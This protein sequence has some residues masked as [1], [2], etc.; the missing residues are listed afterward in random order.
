MR[1]GFRVFNWGVLALFLF[2]G[3]SMLIFGDKAFNERNSAIGALFVAVAL[4]SVCWVPVVA[5][6]AVISRYLE[7]R[8]IFRENMSV[9]EVIKAPAVYVI[10]VVI[11]LFVLLVA[12]NMT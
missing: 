9:G 11:L 7:I 2:L 12:M 10:F 1:G 5:I 3:A 6:A 8:Y 4:G